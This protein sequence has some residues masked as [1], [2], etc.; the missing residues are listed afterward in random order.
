MPP[1]AQQ[2][3]CHQRAPACAS[4][5]SAWAGP[6]GEQ[7]S[8]EVMGGSDSR[9]G[10]CRSR[11]CRRARECSFGPCGQSWGAGAASAC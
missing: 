4:E 3:K 5:H 10:T 6:R 2:P 8:K 9:Y 1:Q 7:H 11:G